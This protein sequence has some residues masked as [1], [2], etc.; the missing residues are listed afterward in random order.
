L[1][2]LLVEGACPAYQI[3]LAPHLVMHGNLEHFLQRQYQEFGAE[4]QTT[5]PA[6]N[7]DLE[8]FPVD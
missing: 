1:Y 6:D 3:A 7:V 4:K 5:H 2:E 8:G